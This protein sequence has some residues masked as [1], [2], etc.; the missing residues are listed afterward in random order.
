MKAILQ[1]V[2]SASVTV[3]DKL[4]SSI[5]RGVL[6][7]AGVGQH[8]TTKDADSL[9]NKIVKLRL[10]P[11]GDAQWKKSVQDI[12]GEILC[13]SQFTLLATTKK[14][15]KPDFHAAA[16]PLPAKELYDYFVSRVMALSAAE[17]V[18]EGVFQAMMDVALVNDGPV[19]Q[20]KAFALHVN[21]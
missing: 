17:R 10:W 20:A 19:G 9:A 21:H 8:D 11:D 16:G 18:K 4:V 13:V 1:R 7:L 15:N 6:V 3:D 5:G 14:G 2:K 12:Q